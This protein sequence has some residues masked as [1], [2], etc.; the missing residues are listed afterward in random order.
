MTLEEIYADRRA[1]GLCGP[2]W[3]IG[4]AY[5]LAKHTGENQVFPYWE[6]DQDRRCRLDENSAPWWSNY[7]S[8]I[9]PEWHK[10]DSAPALYSKET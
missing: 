9:V 7:K 1:K 8:E 10:R 5:A 2:D 6:L 4:I 3:R